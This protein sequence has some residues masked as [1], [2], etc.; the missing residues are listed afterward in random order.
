MAAYLLESPERV[1]AVEFPELI[2][3]DRTGSEREV[4]ILSV[5]GRMVTAAPFPYW[6]LEPVE[7]PLNQI[8]TLRLKRRS[9]PGLTV[10]VILGEV[11]FIISCIRY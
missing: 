6:F 4:K 11:G 10:T 8:R 2:L 7:I 9:Y 3:I 5:Q 1:E